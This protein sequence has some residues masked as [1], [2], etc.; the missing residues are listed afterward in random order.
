MY[1]II[2]DCDG[3]LVD[4]EKWSCGAWLP[5]LQHQGIEAELTDIEAFLGQSDA[6]VLQHFSRETGRTLPS[7]LI[8]EK[9]QQY[10]ELAQGRLQ[11]FVGLDEALAA[12]EQRKISVAVASSGRP[13]KIQFSL[14][15][16][17]LYERFP[18]I[19]SSVEVQHGKPAP[20][21]FL[22]AAQRLGL[23]PERCVVIEDSHFGI[24]AARAADMQALG[25]TSSHDS[26]TLK[27]AGAHRTFSH[28]DQLLDLFGEV[29]PVFL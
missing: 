14:Q 18:I 7:E 11:S 20:D 25:F 29:F 2:F 16:T 24:E 12:L 8:A 22:L 3:V 28:Y 6:A 27:R 5:V 21:L 15:Q 13:Q 23:P 17:G 1:G 10:Y 4:S 9:E 26:A 19:C